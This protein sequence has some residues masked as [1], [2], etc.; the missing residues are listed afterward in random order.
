MVI[1]DHRAHSPNSNLCL[2][3]ILTSV[4]KE[5]IAVNLGGPPKNNLPA[6]KTAAAIESDVSTP[7]QEK[8]TQFIEKLSSV[9]QNHENHDWGLYYIANQ[10]F[11]AMQSAIARHKLAVYPPD[12]VIEIPRN[13]CQTLEFDRADEMIALGYSKTQESLG[14]L[15]SASTETPGSP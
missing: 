12:I 11:D 8:I 13:A 3:S 7:F 9:V 4:Q 6:E 10:S 14:Y 2:T 5:R 15:Q 1:V